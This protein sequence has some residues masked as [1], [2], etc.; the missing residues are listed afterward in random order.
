MFSMPAH[1][2]TTEEDCP[3]GYIL[4]VTESFFHFDHF[5]SEK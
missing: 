1:S 3:F 5:I 4:I 2:P